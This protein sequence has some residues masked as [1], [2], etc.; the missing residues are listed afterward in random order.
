MMKGINPV[1]SHKGKIYTVCT[2]SFSLPTKY[3][4]MNH[5][6]DFQSLWRQLRNEVRALQLKGYY[7]DG[8][9]LKT[10]LQSY[11]SPNQLSGYWSAGT[12]LADSSTIGGQDNASV[13]FPEYMVSRPQPKTT[14]VLIVATYLS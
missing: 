12:R 3:Q 8:L 1:S 10:P 5:G 4:H 7:G 11:I 14:S 6:S 13:E 2:P 9:P